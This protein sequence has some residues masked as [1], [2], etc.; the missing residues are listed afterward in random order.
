M[1]INAAL[2]ISLQSLTG[3]TLSGADNEAGNFLTTTAGQAVAFPANSNSVPFTLAINPANAQLVY[4][5]ATT[6]CVIT[7]NNT[8]TTDVQTFAVTGTPTGGV[9]PIAWVNSNGSTLVTSVNYNSNSSTLQTALQTLAGASNVNC[10]GGPF[11]GSAINATFA[12][13]LNTGKQPVFTV[14]N[15]GLTGGSSPNV[16]VTHAV[17]GAPTDTISL[18]AG[19]P[20]IWGASQGYGS[21]PFSANT[22]AGFM[23]CNA[24]TL[25]NLGYLTT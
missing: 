9:I 4:L 21:C 15:A 17:V 25:L 24:A 11:P 10:S 19:I 16:T 23:T 13:S 1:S 8:N 2:V 3:A 6:N 20:R 5:C 14:S 22:N 7:T 18:V 12:G